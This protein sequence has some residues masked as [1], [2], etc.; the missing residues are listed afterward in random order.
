MSALPGTVTSP[1]AIRVRRAVDVRPVTMSRV[2]RSE[3]IKFRTLRSSWIVLGVTVVGV[4]V[5]GM[6]AGYLSKSHWPTMTAADRASFNP[7]DQSLLGVNLA[8]LTIGVLG[9]LIITGEYATGMIKATLG[10]VPKR[11]PVL[12]AKAAVFA[13]VTFV[14]CLVAVFLAFVGGQAL[15]GSHGVSLA[16][17][18]ALRAVF[19]AALYLTVVGVIGMALGFLIRSTAGGI[20]ALFGILLILPVIVEALPHSWSHT[21]GPYL[22]SS[23]GQAVFTMH[24]DQ[25][26][27]SPWAGFG[28]FLLYAAAGVAAATVA[29]RRRD[30]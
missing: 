3:W 21:V 9:V 12:A 30:A 2:V 10:A 14:S 25:P 17:A 18:G 24:S 29:L 6:L 1:R 19:G 11:V 8:Q 15:L 4:A 16:H 7:I 28:I 20:A 5:I 22:P 27:L 23:A 26:M 13:A